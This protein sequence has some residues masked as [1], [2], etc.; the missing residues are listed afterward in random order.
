MRPFGD[1]GFAAPLAMLACILSTSLPGL[2]AADEVKYELKEDVIYGRKW[3]TALTLD[4]YSPKEKNGAG[5]IL[6]QSGGWISF[7]G[8]WGL[9]FMQELLKRDYTVFTVAHGSQPKYTIPEILEDMHRS[10]RF[11]RHNAA[12]YGIER[13][14]IG[15]YGMSSGGHLAVMQ[16][17]AAK[18]GDL[19]AQDPVDREDSRVQAVACF[20]PPTDFLNYGQTG[21]V[22][23]GTGILK[24]FHAPFEFQKMNADS[25]N[26]MIREFVPVTDQAKILEIGKAIS[27]VYQVDATDAPMLTI[28]GD[29]DKLVPFQQAE[30]MDR[31]LKEAGVPHKLI[32]R[33]GA[34]HGWK[35]MQ[36]DIALFGDW[37][38]KYLSKPAQNSA[39]K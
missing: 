26:P 33:K 31:R 16:G 12:T 32:V 9:P 7:K 1:F 37:F 29:A 39:A 6:V 25:K 8:V 13:N 20:F 11:I 18:P 23:L 27:P 14:R 21:N 5:V 2:S 19:N 34:G 38:D 17:V 35:D 36:K 30:L 22:A 10:V 28:H 15:V 24:D 4:V 3:G